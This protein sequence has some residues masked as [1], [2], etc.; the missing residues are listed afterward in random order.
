MSNEDPDFQFG[1]VLIGLMKG[2]LGRTEDE[3]LWNRLL[4]HQS[5]VRDYVQVLGL[6]LRLDEAEGFA[7]LAQRQPT[8]GESYLPRLMVRHRLSYQLSLLLALLRRRLAEQDA[9][10]G[11]L[12]LILTLEDMQTMVSV[13]LPQV[14]NE[15]RRRDTIAAQVAKAE[16]LGFLRRLSAGQQIWEVRRILA[17]FIDAQWLGEFDAKLETYKQFDG[18]DEPEGADE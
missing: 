17:A 4:R 6:E 14:G 7:W 11:D 16:D 12:R 5:R 15:A 2:L 10:G 18:D 8:E 13:F 9:K 3:T 1:T